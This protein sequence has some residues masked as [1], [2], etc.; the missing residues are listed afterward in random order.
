VR[1]SLNAIIFALENSEDIVERLSVGNKMK[2]QD[3]DQTTFDIAKPKVA[4][5]LKE[6]GAQIMIEIL[7]EVISDLSAKRADEKELPNYIDSLIND[8]YYAVEHYKARYGQDG[9][10]SLEDKKEFGLISQ[11]HEQLLRKRINR[12]TPSSEELSEMA[13]KFPPPQRWY[14]EE[15]EKPW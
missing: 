11:L 8:L 4:K 3:E 6:C 1:K 9:S 7:I 15:E 5:L 10:D 13:K 14:D 12:L 2:K